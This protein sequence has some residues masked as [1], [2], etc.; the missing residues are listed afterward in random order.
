MGRAS[1]WN[2]R[3]K[4]SRDRA[5]GGGMGDEQER[6]RCDKHP[7]SGNFSDDQAYPGLLT[8]SV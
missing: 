6:G 5:V 4:A 7:L 8:D 3:L 1:G 2:N